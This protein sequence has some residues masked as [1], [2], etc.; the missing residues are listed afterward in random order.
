MDSNG[1]IFSKYEQYTS[2]T[3]RTSCSEIWTLFSWKSLEVYLF[4]KYTK[5]YQHDSV[6]MLQCCSRINEFITWNQ[7]L[8]HTHTFWPCHPVFVDGLSGWSHDLRGSHDKSWRRMGGGGI[9]SW[10]KAGDLLRMWRASLI[11]L[12]NHLSSLTRILVS[13]MV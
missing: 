11:F 12:G 6:I 1:H 5:T 10:L 8:K 9:S 3:F 7:D 4:V 13:S 2:V